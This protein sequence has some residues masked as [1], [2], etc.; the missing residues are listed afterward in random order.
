MHENIKLFSSL[1]VCTLREPSA[2]PRRGWGGSFLMEQRAHCPEQEKLVDPNSHRKAHRPFSG[3]SLNLENRPNSLPLPALP[4]GLL[5]LSGALRRKQEVSD[6]V[7]ECKQGKVGS[8]EVWAPNLDVRRNASL[9]SQL[10]PRSEL[11][12]VG[13]SSLLAWCCNNLKGPHDPHLPPIKSCK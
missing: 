1:R 11:S 10:H 5:Q 2:D 9:P 7:P 13:F 4:L 12:I 6:V 8:P 3:F